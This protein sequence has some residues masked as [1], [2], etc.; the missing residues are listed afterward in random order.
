MDLYEAIRDLH[1]EKKRLDYA[2]AVLESK[3]TQNLPRIHPK[4]RGR[5]GM[6]QEER[7]EVSKRMRAYW[8]ARRTVAMPAPPQLLASAGI[9]AVHAVNA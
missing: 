8:A 4:R 5:K 6:S 2:I 1:D 7:L 3:Q 9:A